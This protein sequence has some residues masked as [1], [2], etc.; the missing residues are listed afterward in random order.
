MV[1]TWTVILISFYRYK[2]PLEDGF[3]HILVIDGVPVIDK[4]K[5]EKLLTKIAKEFTRKGAA[6]KPDDISLPWNDKTGK[7]NG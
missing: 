2:V 3:D 7:S 4:A 1:I 6:I 5:Q